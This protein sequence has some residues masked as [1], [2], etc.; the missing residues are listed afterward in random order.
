MQPSDNLE[1]Y[2]IV[3]WAVVKISLTHLQVQQAL[4]WSETNRGFITMIKAK[5]DVRIKDIVE[6]NRQ[7]W[8]YVDK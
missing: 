7:L 4:C 3:E 6:V 2:L 1:L 8:A 5:D